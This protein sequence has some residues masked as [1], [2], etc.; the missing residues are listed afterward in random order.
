MHKFNSREFYKFVEWEDFLLLEEWARVGSEICIT[1]YT[2]SLLLFY[3]YF[4]QI[5][6]HKSNHVGSICQS[7]CI[8]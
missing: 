3:P 8:P 2:N 7:A 5:I 1:N 6:Y 4:L